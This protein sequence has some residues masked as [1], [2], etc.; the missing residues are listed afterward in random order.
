MKKTSTKPKLKTSDDV[1][2]YLYRVMGHMR[3]FHDAVIVANKIVEF[4][5]AGK[6][7]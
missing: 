1:I 2:A 5:K 6:K 4:Q 3:Y 7:K